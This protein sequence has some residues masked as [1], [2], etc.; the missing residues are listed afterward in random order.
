MSVLVGAPPQIIRILL[1]SFHGSKPFL[2]I[3]VTKAPIQE[4]AC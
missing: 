3:S 1:G 2:H 4:V